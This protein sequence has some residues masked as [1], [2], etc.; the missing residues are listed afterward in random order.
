MDLA[1]FYLF[2]VFNGGGHASVDISHERSMASCLA[3][4]LSKTHFRAF[5]NKSRYDYNYRLYGLCA[6]VPPRLAITSS[7][8]RVGSGYK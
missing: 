4:M 6:A 5:P 8:R 2:I 1:T 3:S 7:A